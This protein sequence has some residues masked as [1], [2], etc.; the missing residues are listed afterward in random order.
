MARLFNGTSDYAQATVDLSKV[1]QIALSFWGW[2]DS[3]SSGA[4][5]ALE[6]T[7][8][9]NS[10][11]GFGFFTG[12]P[13]NGQ[14]QVAYSNGSLFVSKHFAAPSAGAWH[15]Y[16]ILYDAGSGLLERVWVDGVEQTL[17]SD[18]NNGIGVTGFA[19]SRLNIM[20]RGGAS[21]FDA[22]RIADLA[23]WAGWNHTGIST[24][25]LS[26][27]L[28]G[29][30]AAML[31]K[32]LS[33]AAIRPDRL[34]LYLP[35]DGGSEEEFF[36]PGRARRA[37]IL[38]INGTT[39]VAGAFGRSF[40]RPRWPTKTFDPRHTNNL[41]SEVDVPY[42]GSVTQAYAPALAANIPVPFISSVTQLYTPQLPEIDPSFISSVTAVYPLDVEGYV[43]VPFISSVTQLYTPQ[44]PQIEVPFIASAT[45]VYGIFSVFNPNWTG[46]G[47][48]NGGET[49]PIRLA[50]NGVTETATLAA[51]LSPD[52]LLVQL[53]GDGG[54][55]TAQPFVAT[56]AAEVL[57][58]YPLGSGNYSVR[59]RAM[60]N[61][62]A[63]AHTAGATVS[64]G[65]SYELAI[66]AGSDVAHAF[67][68]DINSTGSF[69]YD[70]WLICFDSTQAYLAGSRY[71]M[72]VTEVL[73]VFDA[74]AG[75]TGPNRCDAAQPNA[76]ATPT[77]VSDHCP[78]ALSNPALI[79]TDILAGDVAIVRYTNPEATTLDLGPRSAALQSWFG[80]KRVNS[81]DTD[82]TLTDP[83]G[84][85]IDTI[86]S[87]ADP[88]PFTGS[89][90]DAPAEPLPLATGIAPD[91]SDAAGT[92][93]PTPHPVPW[94]STTLPGV[95]RYFT[96]GSPHYSEKGWPIC[97]LA[98]RQGNR[99]IPFWQSWDWHNYAYVYAGFGTDDTFCQLL[100]NRNGIVFD[101][102]P[103]VDLP[104]PQ[105]VDGPD[106][107]WD[108]ATYY[109]AA[110]WYVA[111][112][113]TPYLVF[114][115][116]I[117][118]T[119]TPGPGGPAGGGFAPGVSFPAGPGGPPT[120]TVPGV[121]GGSGGAITPPSGGVL[122]WTKQGH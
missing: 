56:I 104:G 83:A 94:L 51:D 49:F 58:L 106:V 50:P 73:G 27:G 91:A 66:A 80:L 7:D 108:D 86:P 113:G 82:V 30:E 1:N 98:V 55:P 26:F 5:V 40:A 22:G 63:A 21:L 122:A 25:P 46:V 8:D 117:G 23:I 17:T 3:F 68:A 120:I 37:P 67:T 53:T 90:N 2:F 107:V 16:L 60:S 4:K 121:E 102:V 92:P 11:A 48:G 47:P 71:P 29:G 15:H 100:I 116:S 61:T 20:S 45:R 79:T 28:E 119:V 32:G 65:D 87:G 76:I 18:V 42:I 97:C 114:G 57:Y 39:G 36:G 41:P 6:Y 64:W 35:L 62:H 74:G 96:Y 33:P 77:G 78:A 72:H 85:V 31:A 93:I 52:D 34:L 69:I 109:F 38:K 95:D 75:S 43:A 54:F 111:L 70:G 103:A 84:Y 118:G 115:P 44:L 112:F 14:I 105:D 9:F 19:N 101:S 24:E 59:K 110:S 13:A 89:V 12:Y 81:T 99:R 88:G 10:S